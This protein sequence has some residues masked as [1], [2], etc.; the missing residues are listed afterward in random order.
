MNDV[1]IY[2]L[3]IGIGY[4]ISVPFMH[5][6]FKV[7]L[8]RG[9][10]IEVAAVTW[11]TT[12][13]VIMIWIPMH[14]IVVRISG[15]SESFFGILKLRWDTPKPQVLKSQSIAKLPEAIIYRDV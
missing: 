6:L 3:V 8:P 10:P 4:I 12:L 11:P 14:F 15:F 13:V 1:A 5:G 2:M 7:F 9:A